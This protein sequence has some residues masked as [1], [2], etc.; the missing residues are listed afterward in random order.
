MRLS[1]ASLFTALVPRAQG[2]AVLNAKFLRA[3][4]GAIAGLGCVHVMADVVITGTRQ[5]Y[6][7]DQKEITVQLNNTG[8]QP[9]LVQ[10]W[11]DSG[12]PQSSPTNA[13]APFVLSPPVARIDPGKGQSLRVMFVG[14][15]LRKDKESVFWLNVLEIPP[16]MP[17]VA[18]QNQLQMAFRSRIKIFYRPQ[19]GPGTAGNAPDQVQWQV[20]PSA[21]GKGFVLQAY[22]PSAF[23]VS[24]IGLKLLPD[25][26][27][28]RAE[29]G[30]IGP[31]ETRQFA[32]PDLH[33]MPPPGS[34]VEFSAIN[35]YGAHLLI[36]HALGS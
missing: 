27:Q 26:G 3:C 19:L 31:G 10:S 9:A 35:D 12:D 4:L 23:Y 32:L 18:G 17:V 29:D 16:K 21:S 13:S 8:T 14:A 34:Q 25:S 33:S 28:G 6:P 7:A 20:L 2:V 11:I 5:V 22:N 1:P 30:M 36:K 15:P 24:L